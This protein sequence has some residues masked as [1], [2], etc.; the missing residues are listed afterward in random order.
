MKYQVVD[1]GIGMCDDVEMKFSENFGHRKIYWEIS[2]RLAGTG[3]GMPMYPGNKFFMKSR[4]S[5]SRCL[6]NSL[7]MLDQ[8]CQENHG[9]CQY[10]VT[11][12]YQYLN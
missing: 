9:R 10:W 3:I 2:C 11:S 12:L 5:N 6:K 1:D 4:H 7:E 8:K